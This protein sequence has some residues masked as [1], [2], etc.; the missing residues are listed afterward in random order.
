M[1]II[2]KNR[3]CKKLFL[4]ETG[5]QLAILRRAK[6]FGAEKV[7][8]GPDKIVKHET[9]IQNLPQKPAGENRRYIIKQGGMTVVTARPVYAAD[10]DHFAIPNPPRS[11]GLAIQIQDGPQWRVKRSKKN[12][13]K[14]WTPDGVGKLP[15]FFSLRA[16]AFEL[17]DG[18]DIFLWA[19]VYAM[20]DY[21]M[22]ED[23]TYLV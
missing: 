14:I 1:I 15:D 17:P 13:V 12:T 4:D 19:G 5:K 10:A 2:V 6:L 20:I 23:D 3:F 11:V 22:H 16:Q 18:S 7:V 8:I 9:G 21:M